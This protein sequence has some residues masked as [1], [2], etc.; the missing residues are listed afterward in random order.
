MESSKS[1]GVFNPPPSPRSCL[2]GRFRRPAKAR[3]YA[4]GRG[5]VGECESQTLCDWECVPWAFVSHRLYAIGRYW[6]G[7]FKA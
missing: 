4:I 6:R 5:L 7:P 1:K 3:V 2:L